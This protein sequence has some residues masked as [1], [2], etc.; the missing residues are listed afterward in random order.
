[1]SLFISS[2]AFDGTASDVREMFDERLGILLGSVVSGVVGYFVLS[3]VLSKPAR[4]AQ[5]G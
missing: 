2:L 1:M 5:Q 3:R 4:E